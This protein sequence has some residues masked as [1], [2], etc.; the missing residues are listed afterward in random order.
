M[1]HNATGDPIYERAGYIA[2]EARTLRDQLAK[3]GGEA[4]TSR[5]GRRTLYITEQTRQIL[6]HLASSADPALTPEQAVRLATTV[7]ILASAEA[8][9]KEFADTEHELHLAASGAVDA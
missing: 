7:K 6:E 2:G 9:L 4:R 5:T 8:A 1:F 3:H